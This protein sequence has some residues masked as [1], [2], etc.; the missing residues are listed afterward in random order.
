MRAPPAGGENGRRM[1]RGPQSH[2]VEAESTLLCPCRAARPRRG[3]YACLFRRTRASE[4]TTTGDRGISESPLV[5]PTVD[6]EA[7]GKFSP[8]VFFFSFFS[9]PIISFVGWLDI[10][11]LRISFLRCPPVPS[12][13]IRP[14]GS[15][16]ASER[17]SVQLPRPF[18]GSRKR[19]RLAASR[20]L[21]FAALLCCWRNADE[22]RAEQDRSSHSERTNERTRVQYRRSPA[23]SGGPERGERAR[24]EREEREE[25][26]RREDV[27]N[28]RRKQTMSEASKGVGGLIG[29]KRGPAQDSTGARQRGCMDGWPSAGSVYEDAASVRPFASTPSG[30][31]KEIYGMRTEGISSSS[32]AGV[33][34]LACFFFPFRC[35][36]RAMVGGG[37]AVYGRWWLWMWW[38]WWWMWMWMWWLWWWWG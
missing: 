2:L 24:E 31:P 20:R 11:F 22:D 16:G 4:R 33:G 14:A 6:D 1:Y 5:I 28:S 26:E 15:E 18:R 7:K 19:Y 32:A 23:E 27:R 17:A 38:M 8:H 36:G 12:P 30:M 3:T 10:I 34:V 25:R 35:D 29:G 21:T 9:F 37:V 13:T